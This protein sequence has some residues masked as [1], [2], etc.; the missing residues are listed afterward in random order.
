[1]YVYTVTNLGLIIY[2]CLCS[3]Q[4][5]NFV[6]SNHRVLL[7]SEVQAIQRIFLLATFFLSKTT[8]KDSAFPLF[9]T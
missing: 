4:F 5:E 8:T 2:L 9:L 3:C 6:G 1:M 7:I